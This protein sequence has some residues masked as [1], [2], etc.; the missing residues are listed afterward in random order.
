MNNYKQKSL[1]ECN[2]VV[3]VN[4]K[5]ICGASVQSHELVCMRKKIGRW[6]F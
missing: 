1:H 3:Y 2:C 4:K 6:L 5:L